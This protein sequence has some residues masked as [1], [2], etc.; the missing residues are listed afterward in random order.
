MFGLGKPRSKFGK[1]L[2]RRGIQ[3][4]EVAN[5][6][7]LGRTTISNMASNKDYKPRI[8]TFTKLQK[9]LKKMGYNVEYNDF[10]M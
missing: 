7:G 1:W 10:W 9:G 2:D 4:N 5:K 8:S 3:Q 6:A